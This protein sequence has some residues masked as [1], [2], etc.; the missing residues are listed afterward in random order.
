MSTPLELLQQ[1][2]DEYVELSTES[3][4]ELQQALEDVSYIL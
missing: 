1:E 4:K 2:Y 3:E